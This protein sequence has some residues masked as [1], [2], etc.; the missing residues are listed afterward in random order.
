MGIKISLSG[1]GMNVS[2]LL[3]SILATSFFSEQITS[4][5]VYILGLAA[6]A[7]FFGFYTLPIE[8]TEGFDQAK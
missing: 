8:P 5:S 6:L 4:F 7:V 2:A 1:L 3:S